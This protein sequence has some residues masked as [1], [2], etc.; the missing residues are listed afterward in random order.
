MAPKYPTTGS[1]VNRKKKTPCPGAGHGVESQQ[2]VWLFQCVLLFEL[3]PATV[4]GPDYSAQT[5]LEIL[6]A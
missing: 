3:A 2:V 6:R 5:K 4:G 1:G